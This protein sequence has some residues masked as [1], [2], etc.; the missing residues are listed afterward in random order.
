MPG[1]AGRGIPLKIA[2]S[3]QAERGIMG[4]REQKPEGLNHCVKR[5]SRVSSA[6]AGKELRQDA[7][8]GGVTNQV[9]RTICRRSKVAACAA[10]CVTADA[11]PVFVAVCHCR[12]CQK[13]TGSAFAFLIE[14]PKTALE[15]RGVLKTFTS[16]ADS[17]RPILRHF[18]PECGSSIAEEPSIRPGLIIINGG[19]LDDPCSITPPMEIYC[20]RALPWVQLGGMQRFAE[21][22][23]M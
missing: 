5:A 22:P 21:M 7:G 3:Q 10:L 13:Q 2:A 17:G 4:S 15:L 8:E 6:A 14:I 19:T 11:E 18:C 12:D 16:L 20:D 1:I 9:G 23:P